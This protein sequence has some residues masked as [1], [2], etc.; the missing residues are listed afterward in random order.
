[1]KPFIRQLMK[2]GVVIALTVGVAVL[3]AG[4]LLLFRTEVVRR[5]LCYAAAGFGIAV[6]GILATCGLAGFLH[7]LSERLFLKR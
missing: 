4:I 1:M 6:G 5:L 3:A 7:R 2:S